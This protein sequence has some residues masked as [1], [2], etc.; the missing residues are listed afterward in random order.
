MNRNNSGRARMSSAAARILIAFGVVLCTMFSVFMFSSGEQYS[1]DVQS[2]EKHSFFE[3][4]N[5]RVTSL[6]SDSLSEVYA[7]PKVYLLPWS[8][9]PAPVAPGENYTE[10]GY[11]DETIEVEYWVER[12][13]DS[14]AHFARI[15]IAHPTQ[16]RTAFAGGKYSSDARYNPQVIARNVNAVI[17]VNGDYVNY[18][19]GGVIVRQGKLY[20]N[21]PFGWDVLLIDSDGDFHIMKDT[22]VASSGILEEYDIVNSLEFGPSLVVD[23]KMEYSNGESGCGRWNYIDSPRTAV[24]QI[25]K[26]TYL[27]CCVEGRVKNSPGVIIPELAQIMYDR[28]CKQAINLD[29]GQST[30]MVFG[31]KAMN[32]P[33]WGGQRVMSDIIYCATALPNE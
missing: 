11:K 14:N 10:S 3:D 17:A 23:G 26:L 32:V 27:F 4:V 6:K 16:L 9:E 7:L 18:R 29:G 12:L 31:G 25:D 24:G 5:A 30:T 33:L 21:E 28:G 15:K 2:V 19:S 13:Y 20:R 22:K 8:E 1:D